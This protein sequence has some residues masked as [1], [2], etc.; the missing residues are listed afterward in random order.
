MQN[1]K[2][3]E[4]YEI[5]KTLRMGRPAFAEVCLKRSEQSVIKY[6]NGEVNPPEKV[7][8]R[9]RKWM[10]LYNEIHRD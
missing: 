4:I 7:M 10:N 9:A 3:K 5:R 1:E 2:G 6:E 8:K